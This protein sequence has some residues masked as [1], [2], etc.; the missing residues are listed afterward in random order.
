MD[1]ERVA[2]VDVGPVDL[3]PASR[4]GLVRCDELEPLGRVAGGV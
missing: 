1:A 3:E 4:I 2:A